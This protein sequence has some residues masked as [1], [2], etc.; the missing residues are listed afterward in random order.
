MNACRCN[1]YKILI[2]CFHIFITIRIFGDRGD[3]RFTINC[4]TDDILYKKKLFIILTVKNL[5]TLNAKYFISLLFLDYQN[6]SSDT[7][8]KILFIWRLN[9]CISIF[10]PCWSNLQELQWDVVNWTKY[11]K[12]LYKTWSALKS[13]GKNLL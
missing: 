11:R 7:S 2:F 8:D 3:G 13:W 5:N 4:F 12:M 10:F 9:K 1:F 6:N